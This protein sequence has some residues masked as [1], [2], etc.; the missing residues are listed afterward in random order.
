MV[1]HPDPRFRIHWVM[2]PGSESIPKKNN[3]DTNP[4]NCTFTDNY[5][6][7]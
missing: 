4:E 7:L 5:L 6:H 3:R 2:G 1:A